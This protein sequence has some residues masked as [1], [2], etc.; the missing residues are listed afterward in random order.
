MPILNDRNGDLSK[1]WYVE[2][3]YRKDKHGSLVRQRIY[4]GLSSGTAKERYETAQKIIDEQTRLCALCPTPPKQNEHEF[5][6]L[7]QAYI[8]L[9]PNYLKKKSV[10]TYKG[11]LYHF[12]DYINEPDI[13]KISKSHIVD[14]HIHS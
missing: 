2:F 4:S 11:K 14:A 6:T 12:V 8:D 1:Q 7:V 10:S 9:M 13:T 5:S 3:A